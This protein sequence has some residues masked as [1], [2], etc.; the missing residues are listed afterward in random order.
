VTAAR[1]YTIAPPAAAEPLTA[2]EREVAVLVALGQTNREIAARL[3]VTLRT[4]ESHV[5]RIFA[6]LGV[7]SRVQL[8]RLVLIQSLLTWTRVRVCLQ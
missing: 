8:A 5:E 7:H 6:K 1:P 3:V 4:A 2:R